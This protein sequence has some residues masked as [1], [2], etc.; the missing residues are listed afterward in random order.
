[1]V[2]DRRKGRFA[3]TG[4][5]ERSKVEWVLCLCCGLSWQ[6]WFAISKGEEIAD[7]AKG[8]NA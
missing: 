2:A 4:A 5:T 3:I 7:S 6:D 1:M 8:W